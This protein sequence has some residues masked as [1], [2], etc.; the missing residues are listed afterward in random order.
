MSLTRVAL[1]LSMLFGVGC[2]APSSRIGPAPETEHAG[3]IV[4]LGVDTIMVERFSRSRGAIEG[5]IVDRSPKTSVLHY[6]FTTDTGGQITHLEATQRA[7]FFHVTA[8]KVHDGFNVVLQDGDSTRRELVAAPANAIPLFGR[9]LAVYEVITARLRRAGA[10]SVVVPILDPYQ[11][12]VTEHTVHRI[13][14][15][16]VMIP[17]TFPRGER[18]RVD[19]A[20]RMLGVSGLATSYKWLTTRVADLDIA[21]LARSFAERDANGASLGNYSSR[22][23]ARAMID[24]AHI[25]IDYGRP[26]KRGRV[27]FG[28]LVPWNEVWRTGADL[29]THL[30]TDRGLRL[31][32]ILLPAGTYTLYTLPSPAEWKLIVN[33]RT[34]QLGL[35]YDPAAGLG[36]VDMTVTRPSVVTERLTITVDSAPSGGGVLRIAWDNLMAAVPFSVLPASAS[37]PH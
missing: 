12:R 5:D 23:T 4:R 27:I 35:L 1:A 6:V 30:T 33:R 37:R 15:D 20:G 7:P 9:S 31:N 17:V 16:S 11:F 26:S 28:A 2:A 19:P 18:A 34:G 36:R 29:A 13:D 25:A 24:G 32:E 8:A 21:A 3:F 22:D 14:S 10:D